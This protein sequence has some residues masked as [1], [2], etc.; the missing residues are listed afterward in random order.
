MILNSQYVSL[1][2]LETHNQGS[3]YRRDYL[4]LAK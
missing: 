4:L 2:T 1:G 3:V